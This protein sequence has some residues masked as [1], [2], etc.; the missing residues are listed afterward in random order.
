MPALISEDFARQI[1]LLTS[2]DKGWGKFYW[3]FMRLLNG[4]AAAAVVLSYVRNRA[5]AQAKK[6]PEKLA[7]HRMFVRCPAS[8]MQR[9]LCMGEWKQRAAVRKL[10]DAGLIALKPRAKNVLWVRFNV[11]S[12]RAAVDALKAAAPAEDTPR[13]PWK[14]RI[15]PLETTAHDPRK[16]RR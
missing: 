9:V 12:V 4:D 16:P 2:R 6:C 10:A 5:A 8:E 13:V 3:S 11:D 14:P 7:H 15:T 1:K